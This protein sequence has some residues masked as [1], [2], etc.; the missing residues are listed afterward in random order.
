MKINTKSKWIVIFCFAIPV[1]LTAGCNF[2]NGDKQQGERQNIMPTDTVPATPVDSINPAWNRELDSMLRVTATAKQDTDLAQLYYNIGNEYV[3]NDS[4]KAKE[5]YLKS[6][7]LSKKLN[8]SEGQYQFAAAYT[9][10]LNREGLIDSSIVIHQQALELAKKEMKEIWTAKILTNIGNCYYYKSWFETALTYYNEALSI[11]EKRDEKLALAYIYYLMSAV[12]YNL[13]MQDENLRYSEKALSMLNETPESLTRAYALINYAIALKEKY[14]YKKAE[15][16][17]MEAQR[18]CNLNND[19]NSL[20]NIYINLGEIA[21]QKYKWEKTEMYARKSLDISSE[22]GNIEGYCASNLML[23]YVEEYKGNFNKSEE[24]TRLALDTAKKYDLANEKMHS[25]RQFSDLSTARHDFRNY[26]F[27]ALKTDSLQQTLTSEQ[28]VRSAKEMEIKYE[29]E[30]KELKITAL[31]K[32]KQLMTWLGIAGG[33]VL[34]LAMAAFFFLWRWTTQKRKLVESKNKQLEQEKQLVATQSV[35]DGETQE[36]SRLARDLHDGLGSML[37]GVKLNLMEMK[38]GVKLEYPDVER[39][40]KAL[41]LL[42]DSVQE[43]RRVA[44][45]LMP[46]S[47][48]R[49]GLKPAVED[50][51]RSFAPTVVFDY[52]GDE[53]RLDPMMEVV[54]Y[55]SIHELVNNALKYSG[56]SQIMVQIMQEPD[57]IA[58]TVQ[59]DGCGFD[60]SAE[61]K[62]TGLQNIRDRIAS[63]SGTIQI[64]SKIEEGTEVNVELKL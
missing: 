37:T 47:L 56:A 64:D 55:R 59:D 11:F 18:I 16:S 10:I 36:R 43:M 6:E 31:E 19:R 40:D 21:Q 13:N 15:N 42:D 51:C 22:L 35:L 39:F 23:A 27:Y 28:T 7:A 49:F 61:T 53:A 38:N 17:L 57:R 60:P 32:E 34:L 45:H 12:Y 46:D 63:F 30:K 54:I 41:G 52:F 20:I 33:V 24:Y 9:D 50:F 5:Y 8:W 29:T 14:D 2:R 62:G 1:L 44:H 48:S 25:Y 4:K 26:T 58:F 3:N